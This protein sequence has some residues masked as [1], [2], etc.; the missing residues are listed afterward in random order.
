MQSITGVLH[1][2]RTWR[3]RGVAT[4]TLS[5]MEGESGDPST[6]RHWSAISHLV[7]NIEFTM[8][9]VVWYLFQPILNMGKSL[10]SV[11]FAI[12]TG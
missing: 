4:L 1:R 11:V 9:R 7:R 10:G 5:W 2:M 6:A 12:F 8:R 3:F